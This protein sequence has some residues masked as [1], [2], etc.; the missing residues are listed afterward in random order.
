MGTQ[1]HAFTLGVSLAGC[2]FDV[3]VNDVPIFRDV[4]D[5]FPLTAR[6]GINEYLRPG[7]NQITLEARP[8]PGAQLIDE[9]AD[10]FEISLFGRDGR[11][12]KRDDKRLFLLKLRPG[13]LPAEGPVVEPVD[14]GTGLVT[15]DP[16]VFAEDRARQSFR[17]RAQFM[18]PEDS[19]RW[20]WMASETI[21]DTPAT[22]AE[23]RKLFGDWH[24][25]LVARNTAWIAP[26][27]A[28]RTE[29]LARAL[30]VSRGE[31]AAHGLFEAVGDPT[32]SLVPPGLDKSKLMVFGGG[33][34]VQLVRWDEAPILVYLHDNGEE[35]SYFP[36]I[37]RRSEFQWLVCR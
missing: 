2:R 32:R 5:G 11:A 26:V 25:R 37:L 29:E 21:A 24:S 10:A 3:R 9:P 14:D 31:T 4:E 23:L 28:E 18:L 1:A 35:A 33:K 13:R 15:L 34:L 16:N 8:R 22:L 19:H 36:L 7:G 12:P 17:M 20:N 6:M 27:M 30:F